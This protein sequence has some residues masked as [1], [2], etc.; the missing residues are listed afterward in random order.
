MKKGLTKKFLP[1][2]TM[3]ALALAISV[4][5][6]PSMASANSDAW[7]EFGVNG[8][9]DLDSASIFED[10]NTVVGLIIALGGFWIICCLIFA[11]IKLAAAQGG[12][13]QARTAGFIG[14]GMAFIGGW[15]IMKA[16]DI[17]GFIAGFGG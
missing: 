2:L 14:I 3:V 1:L 8:E 5:A 6:E 4:I 10:L 16:H 13:P 17:A 7:K 15:V 11:G 9:G 12:N